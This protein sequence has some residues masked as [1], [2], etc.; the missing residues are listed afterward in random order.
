MQSEQL[1][2]AVSIKRDISRGLHSAAEER[3]RHFSETD[4]AL[5]EIVKLLGSFGQESVKVCEAY[6]S[7]RVSLR[8]PQSCWFTDPDFRCR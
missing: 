3:S 1:L 5:A 2:I 7:L 8:R 6:K 4:E